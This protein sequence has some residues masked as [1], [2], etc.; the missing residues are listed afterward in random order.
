MRAVWKRGGGM[1][2]EVLEVW[3]EI[4]RQEKDGGGGAGLG[5][6]RRRGIG[7]WEEDR[8]VFAPPDRRQI[9]N[10]PPTHLPLTR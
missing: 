6:I 1:E 2:W 3:V 5:Q 7:G 10:S 9:T 8:S 4:C